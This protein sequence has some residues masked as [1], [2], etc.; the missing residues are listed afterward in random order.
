M[1]LT[2]WVLKIID[3]L[4]LGTLS[5]EL[6]PVQGYQP[7]ALGQSAAA[8]GDTLYVFGGIYHGEARNT[9]HMLNTG[10][11][12]PLWLLWFVRSDVVSTIIRKGCSQ[13]RVAWVPAQFQAPHH[14]PY[15]FLT[16]TFSWENNSFV[17]DQI[18]VWSLLFHECWLYPAQC[19]DM[20][21]MKCPKRPTTTFRVLY[22]SHKALQYNA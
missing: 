14:Y 5:W 11:N 9:M 8:I 21:Y 10:N 1:L 16:L 3:H 15:H 17:Q 2:L 4:L 22:D 12:H 7:R 20:Y 6:C 13:Q 18:F 19:W